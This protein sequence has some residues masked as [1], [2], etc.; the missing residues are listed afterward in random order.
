MSSKW[1]P[2]NPSTHFLK[3]FAF[4]WL[5][6]LSGIGFN[7]NNI[8]AQ[9]TN[10]TLFPPSPKYA[11]HYLGDTLIVAVNNYAGDYYKVMGLVLVKPEFK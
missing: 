4:T 2:L 7:Y 1:N 6:M 8:T 9:C 3:L 10:T 5:V 11:P